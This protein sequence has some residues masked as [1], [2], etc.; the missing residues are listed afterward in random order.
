MAS[1]PRSSTSSIN[2]PNVPSPPSQQRRLAEFAT[3][4]GDFKLAV[5]V[6]ESLRKE[7]KGGSVSR[8]SPRISPGTLNHKC[9]D[10][11]PILVSSSPAL[12]LHASNALSSLHAGNQDIPPQALFRALLAAVRWETAIPPQDFLSDVLEGERW[13]VWAAGSV[14][15]LLF[16]RIILTPLILQSEEAPA[17]LLIGHAAYLTSKK[18]ARR[19][20]AYWYAVAASRLEKC[21]IVRDSLFLPLGSVF[22]VP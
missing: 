13:L 22:I 10:I 17:A 9:Q 20:A 2:G 11:L 18:W 8:T 14:G 21:G 3:I 6:W 1:L 12:S 19:R 16:P 4:L 7:S 5:T 15:H